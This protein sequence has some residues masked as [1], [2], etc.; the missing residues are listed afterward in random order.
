MTSLSCSDDGICII[1]CPQVKCNAV[2]IS[3][4]QS[5]RTFKSSTIFTEIITFACTS[6]VYSNHKLWFHTQ[7][8]LVSGGRWTDIASTS[9]CV[10]ISVQCTKVQLNIIKLVMGLWQRPS[11]C[12]R[13]DTYAGF[14]FTG[15]ITTTSV[16]RDKV[17]L[18]ILKS[19]H[20]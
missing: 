15:I 20:C 16:R 18:Y 19:F 2:H 13:P 1:K 5:H 4:V 11:R 3:M 9:A 14:Y 12:E 6:N 7:F 17:N 8:K 10:I